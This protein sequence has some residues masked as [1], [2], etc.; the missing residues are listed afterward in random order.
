MNLRDEYVAAVEAENDL[1]RERI[2]SLEEVL[3]LRIETPPVLGLTSHE[4]KL[5]GLLLKRDER[6]L[7]QACIVSWPR[8]G[9]E[10]CVIP[11]ASIPVIPVIHTLRPSGYGAASRW[12][13]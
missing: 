13:T 7:L 8:P 9:R 1:L 12:L 5:F 6:T 3:G 2:A 4:A 10:G 11:W